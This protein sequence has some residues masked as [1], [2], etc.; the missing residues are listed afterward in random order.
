MLQ[1]LRLVIFF[2]TLFF[3]LYH[4]VVFV[5]AQRVCI[6]PYRSAVRSQMATG[7]GGQLCCCSLPCEDP[8]RVPA[9]FRALAAFEE[10]FAVGV[11]VVQSDLALG[12]R[13]ADRRCCRAG[14]NCARCCVPGHL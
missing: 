11:E 5:K 6:F 2:S 1:T 9:G 4:S 7:A 3:L 13:L 8:C 10:L 14:N 12:A